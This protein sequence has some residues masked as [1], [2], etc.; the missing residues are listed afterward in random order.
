MRSRFGTVPA[1]FA[2]DNVQC[3]GSEQRIRDCPHRTIDN[4]SGSEGAGVICSN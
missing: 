4:C 2:M 3:T 1:D